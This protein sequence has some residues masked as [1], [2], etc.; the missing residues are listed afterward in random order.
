MSQ[1]CYV[2]YFLDF[3]MLSLLNSILI[4]ETS[5]FR[6]MQMLRFDDLWLN[7]LYHKN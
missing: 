4:L 6:G 2:F 3:L 1:V 7:I 5:F